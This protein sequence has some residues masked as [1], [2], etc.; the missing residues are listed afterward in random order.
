VIKFNLPTAVTVILGILA[1]ILEYL[2]TVT[3]NFPVSWHQAIKYG[4][5]LVGLVGVTPLV[6]ANIGAAIRN[7][8]HMTPATFTA[9]SAGV[10]ALAAAVS[11]FSITGETKGI[12]LGVVAFLS[13]IGFGITGAA[14][15]PAVKTA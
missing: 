10:Y 12:I 3:F 13:T 8:L 11:T 9:V 6:G 5:L 2:N 15:V 14:A 1:G 4:I 7:V